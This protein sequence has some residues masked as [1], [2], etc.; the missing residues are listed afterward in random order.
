MMTWM[1]FA[2]LCTG[3]MS[4]DAVYPVDS[5]SYTSWDGNTYQV[6][7]TI[8]GAAAEAD[9]SVNCPVGFVPPRDESDPRQC[10][11]VFL[12]QAA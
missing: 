1:E 7:C 9:F 3:N 2:F 12:P 4:Q 5:S 6:P 10:I 8:P 11:K